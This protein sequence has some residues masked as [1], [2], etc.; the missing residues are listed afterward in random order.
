MNTQT[1]QNAIRR[2]IVHNH[3]GGTGKTMFSVHLAEYL[4]ERGQ[5]W[6]L[7]DAD[8]QYNAISWLTGHSWDGEGA[9][10]L[11]GD[12]RR[13]EMIVTVDPD[14]AVG[15]S[16]FVADTP[17]A[18]DALGRLEREGIELGP[19]DLLVCP[20]SGRFGID[21]AI[22]VAEEVAPTGCRV[23]A[24]LNMTDPNDDHAT[25]EIRAV[26]E[27]EEVEDLGIEVFKMAIPRND[28]YLRQAELQGQPV[29]D[30][31]Y[32]RSTHAVKALQAFC[33]WVAEG[34]PP[35]ANQMGALA[36]GHPESDALDSGKQAR[37]TELQE[38]L[39]G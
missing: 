27:L 4:V 13:T 38:R 31:S 34:A 7:L 10:R 18:G 21:G 20:V 17:P 1:S 36:T 5:E 3:K 15:Q 8:P 24:V 9:L 14:V 23:V 29:W 12:G 35:E 32:A 39:W 25:E 2:I 16:H 33:R 11:P 26:R 37:V 19:D 30:I 6:H 28:K 22:K